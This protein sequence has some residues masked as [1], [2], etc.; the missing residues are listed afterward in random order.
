MDKICGYVL[1]RV[2]HWNSA[3]WWNRKEWIANKDNSPFSRPN[4]SQPRPG[5]YS[6]LGWCHPSQLTPVYHPGFLLFVCCPP[7][8]APDPFAPPIF[9]LLFKPFSSFHHARLHTHTYWDGASALCHM[10][11][12]AC[13]IICLYCDWCDHFTKTCNANVEIKM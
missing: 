8:Q 11:Q 6:N 2:T 1:E 4:Q 10:H 7:S 5:D 9:S 3:P 13:V 12:V